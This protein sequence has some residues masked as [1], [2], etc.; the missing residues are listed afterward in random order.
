M[1]SVRAAP[2]PDEFVPVTHADGSV[3]KT[4]AYR[5]DGL[6]G[7]DLFELEAPMIELI[8]EETV[9]YFG[10]ALDLFRKL[11]E[12]ASKSRRDVRDHRLSGSSS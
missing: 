6:C 4:Y 12:I 10:A 9:G 1:V 2:K 7:V 11:V 5:E 3:A 8:F